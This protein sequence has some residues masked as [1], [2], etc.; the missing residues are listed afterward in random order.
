MKLSVSPLKLKDRYTVASPQRSDFEVAIATLVETGGDI[1][2]SQW[3]GEEG[4]V[5]KLWLRTD[6]QRFFLALFDGEDEEIG[7]Y[8]ANLQDQVNVGEQP[9]TLDINGDMWPIDGVCNDPK[10]V[11]NILTH[12]RDHGNLHGLTDWLMWE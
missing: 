2:L 6:G 5:G 1:G 8:T 4:V 10:R 12:Y 7:S 3:G 11:V 9:Q